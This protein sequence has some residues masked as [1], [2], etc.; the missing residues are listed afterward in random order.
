MVPEFDE[1]EKL[2]L[3][4]EVLGFYLSSH[5]LAEYEQTLR[6]FCSHSSTQCGGLE[7]R[8][9]VERYLWPH[10]KFFCYVPRGIAA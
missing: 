4:K 9:E 6:T 7:H 8:T 10:R 1:K 5:P 2:T 3:E